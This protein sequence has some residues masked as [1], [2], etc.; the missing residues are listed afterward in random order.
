MRT[1]KLRAIS[2]ILT[3]AACL[4]LFGAAQMALAAG[5]INPKAFNPDPFPLPN[6]TVGVPLFYDLSH[7]C[8]ENSGETNTYTWGNPNAVPGLTFASSGIISGTPATPGTFIIPATIGPS[9]SCPTTNSG[10]FQL[11]V[12][13]PAPPANCVLKAEGVNPLTL[14]APKLVTLSVACSTGTPTSY[15]WSAN[16]GLPVNAS[17][18][19]VQVNSTQT[20]T[21][22]PVNAGGAGNTAS[23]TVNLNAPPS[24]CTVTAD[25]QNPLA[26]NGPKL[27]TLSA[28]C[29]AGNPTSFIWSTNSGLP[30][31][32]SSGQVQ[33]NSTQTF[34][35]TPV[36]AVAP[37]SPVS[38]IV[39]VP[40]PAPPAGCSVTAD[41]TNPLNLSG[42][43]QVTLSAQCSA[44]NPTT[45][46]WSANAGL[47]NTAATGQVQVNSTQ[48]FTV[49]PANAAGPGSTVSVTV[50]VTP[51]TPSGCTVT[52]DGANPLSLS[53]PKQVTLSAQ[54][55]AGNP[56]TFTWSANA[57]L[58][59]TA[60]TGQVQVNSTQ[61]FTVTPANAAGPGSTVSVTVNVTPPTTPPSGCAVTADGANPLNLPG[62]KQVTL[63][64]TCSTGN[65]TA[66]TWS[67][68]AG[69]PNTAASGQ[70]QV[71]ST[72][73]FTVTPANAAGPGNAVSVTVNVAAPPSGCTVT[74]D[75]ANPLNL[76]AAKQVTLSATCSSG[77][78][79]SFTW[80]A[81][82]GLPS[83][84]SS[85][86]VQVNSTQTFTVT[87]A[88]AAGPGNTASVTVNVVALTTSP[89]PGSD[90]Q[91]AAA[92]NPLPGPLVLQVSTTTG[93]PVPGISVTWALTQGTGT[94]SAPVSV[95]NAQG[96]ASVTLTLG[97]E[98]GQRTVRALAG[99]SPPVFFTVQSAEQ[100][101]ITPTEQTAT[102]QQVVA[103]NTPR[104]QIANVRTRLDQLRLQRNPAVA[105]GLKVSFDGKP[106]P[107]QLL[108]Q[109]VAPTKTDATPEPSDPFERNG[110]YVQGDVEVGHQKSVGSASGFDLRTKGLTV[111]IDRRFEGNHVFGAA[112]G[113]LRAD[114][115]VRDDGGTQDARGYSF[116]LYGSYSFAENGY[117]NLIGNVGRNDYDGNRNIS[118][119]VSA[120]SSTSGTQ[121]GV[122]LSAGYDFNSGIMSVGPYG[123]VE[124]VHAKIDPYTETGTQ[125]L[126]VGE[127]TTS[128]TFLTLGAQANWA[129]S[130]SWGV[131]QPNARLEWQYQA[132]GN[133][134]AITAQLVGQPSSSTSVQIA[135][136]DKSYG[137]AAVGVQFILPYSIQA[138]FNFETP[139][140]KSE[141]N[142]QRYTLGVR[143][144]F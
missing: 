69:L 118:S 68:N 72:Q 13:L 28:Q 104:V 33:V 102:V 5:A 123:R 100:T 54:C 24:G 60:A 12:V 48:T 15:N 40:P 20:F 74:A 45:F 50:N 115:T 113:L 121:Y 55:S 22:T 19:T 93:L 62:P 137:L 47:P 35:V 76:S 117:L 75:G 105:Q 91:V 86:Q 59:N 39:T 64:A 126:S 30:S 10:N 52:A 9:P 85:G 49:T 38:V 101:I 51:P 26:L 21:V 57:G 107:W 16:A 143:L 63:S 73:T 140:G 109:A 90:N 6:G 119:G 133:A 18:G 116:S 103:L 61:T 70:V 144:G 110:V 98:P 97:P 37:G 82:A 135:G 41:N 36:N 23:V 122:A 127:Q 128:A 106:L 83:T 77:S 32:V 44:G 112:L 42:P 4:F 129:I 80:S 136:Q 34:T 95:T 29:T 87:P 46:T 11:T 65:P 71:N 132:A 17:S 81:N 89:V 25:G 2:R 67:A 8:P 130:T 84:A 31:N 1:I 66:F 108:A 58:P 14:T 120:S 27:V 7:A 142:G 114:T 138:Y 56:T 131:L 94:L 43:K 79:T 88:N 96:Q 78:P 3:A 99:N 125:A 139:F 124:Y 111:G 134:N 53:G 141:Y 92:N